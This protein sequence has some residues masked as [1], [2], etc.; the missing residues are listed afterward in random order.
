[1]DREEM[2]FVI[3]TEAITLDEVGTPIVCDLNLDGT[4]DW[5]SY[6]I[7]DWMD[8]NPTRYDLYKAAVDFLQMYTPYP[9]YVK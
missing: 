7:I 1:M 4:V 3:G 5:D 2:Y 6:D 9:I 8:L